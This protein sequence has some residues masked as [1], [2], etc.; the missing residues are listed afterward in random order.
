VKVT[1]G[2][3]GKQRDSAATTDRLPPGQYVT[4]EFPVLTAGPT[5]QTPLESWSLALQNGGKLLARWNWVEFES[6]P[7]TEGTFDIHCVTKWSK[8]DTRWRGVMF[9]DLVKAAGLTS[10][11]LMYVMAHCDGG[12]TTNLPAADLTEGKAMVATHFDGLPLPATHGG[13]ARLLVPHLYFWK[14]AKW[15]RRLAFMETDAPGFW[16]SLGYH[17]YG[18]PWRE[19]RYSGD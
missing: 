8:L 1:R 18:D 15:V 7:H 9:D 3:K 10:A 16:E 6:L 2:F 17:I 19:Q 5:Q 14:S 4:G 13:P 12:Y 11:P